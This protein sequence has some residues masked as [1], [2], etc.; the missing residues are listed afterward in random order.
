MGMMPTNNTHRT[1]KDSDDEPDHD[2]RKG[3]QPQ[4]DDDHESFDPNNERKQYDEEVNKLFGPSSNN[5]KGN[6]NNA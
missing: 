2:G 1:L 4:D 3:N 5:I 6:F